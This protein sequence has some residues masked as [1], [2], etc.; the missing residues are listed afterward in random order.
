MENVLKKIDWKEASAKALKFL[1]TVSKVAIIV[2][3]MGTGF[4]AGSLYSRYT[5]NVNGQKMQETH[6]QD[7][8]SVAINERGEIMLVDRKTGTYQMYSDTVGKMIF[9]L[10][11]S[12]IYYQSQTTTVKK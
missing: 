2:V 12:K 3:A 4:A 6:T 1:S 11:A 5:N 7:E 10:Y 9:D 8:T